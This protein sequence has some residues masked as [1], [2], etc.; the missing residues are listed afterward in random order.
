MCAH[1]LRLSGL[2]PYT[3]QLSSGSSP[4]VSTKQARVRYGLFSH[5][6]NRCLSPV[7]YRATKH[8]LSFGVPPSIYS[9]FGVRLMIY[10]AVT[11]FNSRSDSHYRKVLD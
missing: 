8:L 1:R 11:L 6:P 5:L 4:C 2:N 10:F 9:R 7:S 3:K